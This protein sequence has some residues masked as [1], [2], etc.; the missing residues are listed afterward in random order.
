MS[1][2]TARLGIAAV[3]LV[4]AV[5]GGAAVNFVRARAER[6]IVNSPEPVVAM[7]LATL[8]RDVGLSADQREKVR[9]ILLDTRREMIAAHPELIPEMLATFER[10]QNEIADVLTPEQRARYDALVEQRRRAMRQIRQEAQ[11]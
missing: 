8:D 9:A 3:F 2:W 6:R 7:V 11:P 1:R 4:G 5:C 10:T